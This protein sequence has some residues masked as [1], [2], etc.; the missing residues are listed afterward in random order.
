MK[1]QRITL[2]AIAIALSACTQNKQEQNTT[3]SIPI[4]K[5]VAN[6]E[7]CM[8][9]AYIFQED[10]R[11]LPENSLELIEEFETLIEHDLGSVMWY[12]T[13]ADNFPTKECK[14]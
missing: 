10:G 14:T 13:F 12:P 8:V 7:G 3:S 2:C 6:W 5:S 1:L 11:A 9:S 4:A